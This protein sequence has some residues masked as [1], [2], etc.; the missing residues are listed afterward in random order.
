MR[1]FFIDTLNRTVNFSFDFNKDISNKIKNS[2]YNSRF[3]PELELW[4]LPVSEWTLSSIKSIV[5]EFG[6]KQIPEPIEEDVDFSYEKTEVDIAYL[7]G[8]CDAKDFAYTPRDYQLEC[9]GFSIDA[10]NVLLGDDVGLGKTFESILYTETQNLFPCLVITPASVKDQWKE[11]WEEITKNKREVCTIVSSPPKKRP[12]NWDADVVIINYDI[13]GKKQGTGATT[14]FGELKDIKW[15]SIIFDEAHFLKNKTSMRAKAAKMLTKPDDVII[16]MLTGTA[17]MS[18][19]VEIW[20]LLKILKVSHL[21]AEDWY[22]F[23]RR[24]CGGFRGK[25]GWVTDG[26]TNIIELNRKLRESF[27]IRREKRDVLKE[28]PEITKQVIQMPITNITKINKAVENFIEF[29]EEEKGEE[30]AEKAMAAEDLVKLGVLRKMAIEGKLKAIEQYLKDWKESGVK[31]LVFGLHR[32]QLDYLSEK[33]KCN[34]IAGGTSA[35]RKRQIVLDWQKNDDVFLFGNMESAGTGVDG[36][37]D[38]CS[39][40]LI[41]ELPW[42]PSDLVQAIGRLDRSGQKNATTV[43]FALSDLTI[44]SQMWAMLS[45]KEIAAEAVNKGIDIRKQTSGMRDVANKIF[46][47]NKND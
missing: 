21:I 41:I 43:T 45:E 18:K 8:L 27:Y 24:Y 32:E 6:F 19:P 29:I 3:N 23:I 2:D 33:F 1:T 22:Q 34:L 35:T 15:K 42:R 39:N 12:N 44:D 28:L 26:A 16:Q 40:M 38:V 36:L 30:A 11:K 7:T 4:I 5:S 10:G 37:Q 9:L 20:N 25:F 14:R 31:L 13:I 47:Q 46:K 17:I